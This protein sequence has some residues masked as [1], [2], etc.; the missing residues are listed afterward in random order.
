MKAYEYLGVGG[1]VGVDDWCVI[2]LARYA[3]LFVSSFGISILNHII[4]F[5]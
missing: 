1:D 5:C 4:C 2:P 3:E